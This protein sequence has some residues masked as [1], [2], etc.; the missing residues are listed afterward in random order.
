MNSHRN[1]GPP[2]DNKARQALG[3]TLDHLEDFTTHNELR[4]AIV[5]MVATDGR[6]SCEAF[7]FAGTAEI[8]GYLNISA[9]QM[10]A[11]AEFI[12]DKPQ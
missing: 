2:L 4:G 8:V 7:G 11:G 3:Q 9:G 1:A 10:L 6:F 5:I 12:G